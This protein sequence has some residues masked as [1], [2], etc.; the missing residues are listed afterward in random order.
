MHRVG[1]PGSAHLSCQ[2]YRTTIWLSY[3][4]VFYIA[5]RYNHTS[6]GL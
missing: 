1:Y 4:T 6:L 3:R 2:M 5:T